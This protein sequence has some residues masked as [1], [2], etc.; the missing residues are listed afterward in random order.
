MTAKRAGFWIGLGLALLMLVAPMPESFTPEA[1]RVAA[2]ALLM[3][4]W[5]ATEALPHA[6]T[7]LLPLPVLPLIMERAPETVAAAY[8]SPIVLLLL[9]GFIVALT[10]EKWCLHRRI[11]LAVAFAFTRGAR[12]SGPALLA[13]FMAA[14]ALLSAWISNTATTLMLMPIAAETARQAGGGRGLA[15]VLALGVAYAASIGGLATPVGTPTNLI[16]MER[17]ATDLGMTMGF[18]EW[19]RIGL[20]AVLVLLPMAWAVMAL[21]A[22]AETSGQGADVIRSELAAMGRVSA[23]EWRVIGLFGVVAFLWVLPREILWLWTWPGWTP[24]GGESVLA[25]P[26]GSRGDMM[27]AIAGAVASFIIPAGGRD[28]EG[29]RRAEALMSWQTAHRLPWGVVLLFGGGIALAGGV[30]AS[31]LAEWLAG[32][33][34]PLGA[35]PFWVLIL[36]VVLMVVFLTEITSNVAT[37]TAIAP[38]LVALG[39]ATGVAPELLVLPAALAASCAFMLPVAT[40]P[41]AIAFSTGAVT[42]GDMA[43]MGLRINLL[44]APLITLLAVFVLG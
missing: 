26:K 44:A 19:A 23:P 40:A 35:F 15:V 7:A 20:P 31:G 10:I 18:A 21:S 36:A 30:A 4:S 9:G 29:Q 22:R 37:M 38:V 13:G 34:A 14:S 2:L 32:A 17:L 5:W 33:L 41:N 1:R 6:A 3:A 42:G 24:W 43:R 39:A 12:G 25:I 28:E 8:T 27:I 16:A 11:A